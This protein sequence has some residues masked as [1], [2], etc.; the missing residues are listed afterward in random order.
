MTSSAGGD[1]YTV[2][3]GMVE[4]L[5]VGINCGRWSKVIADA[6]NQKVSYM[7]SYFISVVMYSN[8]TSNFNRI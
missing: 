5:R 6:A 4:L 2:L 8:C 3:T 7:T 1:W